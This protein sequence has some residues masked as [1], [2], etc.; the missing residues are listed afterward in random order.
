M[1]IKDALKEYKRGNI[2]IHDPDKQEIVIKKET[3]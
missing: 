1:T 3:L 2:V